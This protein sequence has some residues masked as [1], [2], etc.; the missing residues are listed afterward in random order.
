VVTAEERARRRSK[1][2][3]RSSRRVTLD[4]PQAF[5]GTFD[6]HDDILAGLAIPRSADWKA[7]ESALERYCENYSG[8]YWNASAAPPEFREIRR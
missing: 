3:S 5:G 8:D 2:C 7:F 6:A 4:L 1:K